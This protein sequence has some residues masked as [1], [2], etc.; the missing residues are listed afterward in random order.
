MSNIMVETTYLSKKYG[1]MTAVN[2]VSLSIEQGSIVGLVGKNGA[3]KTTLM[4]LLTGL[5]KPTSGTFRLLPDQQR[6]NTS[7]AALVEQPALYPEMSALDNL[8]AQCLLLGIAVDDTFLKMTLNLVRLA[9]TRQ[10]VKNYSLGMKQRL[11]IAMTF[12]G[13]PELIIL[14]E[15]T[16]GLD[17]QGIADMRETFV[18]MNKEFGTTIVISSHILSELAK[19]AHE[20]FFMDRGRVIKHATA[21]EL[22]Q[23]SAKRLRVTV[24]DAEKA[25]EVLQRYGNVERQGNVIELAGDVPAT[26]IVL[27]LSQEGVTVQEITNVGENLEQ[28]F[29]K[30]LG[31][32][33]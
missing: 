8:R 5:S 4:R 1:S 28:Y 33:R 9:D 18:R 2:N 19:F 27:A 30:L 21:E 23:L 22:A 17:P 6:T 10:K 13:K 3:G 7:V 24:D 29:L 11:A 15:P 14:D 32:A 20:Y 12:V 16:N 25:T 26:E 31:G